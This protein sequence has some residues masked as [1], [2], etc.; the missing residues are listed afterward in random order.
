DRD[1]PNDRDRQRCRAS[2]PHHCACSCVRRMDLLGMACVC[3]RRYR[4]GATNGRGTDLCPALCA[5]HARGDCWEDDLDATD[6]DATSKTG[7][8]EPPRSDHRSQ[9]TGDAAVAARARDGVKLSVRSGGP[10][11]TSEQSAI[12]R[13][14]LLGQLV[15]INS[16][17]EGALWV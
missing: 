9:S 13:E 4:L 3:D 2:S 17:D 15:A 1:N 16:T 10:V 7:A 6:L 14:R 11:L 8:E 5:V 12:L